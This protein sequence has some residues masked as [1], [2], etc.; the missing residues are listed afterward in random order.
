MENLNLRK[1]VAEALGCKARILD[2]G[3]I[4]ECKEVET[5]IRHVQEKSMILIKP[6]EL[7]H[8]AA[9]DALEEYCEKREYVWDLCHGCDGYSCMI[10]KPAPDNYLIL[11]NESN[12]SLAIAICEAIKAAAEGK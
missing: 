6:Y 1:A 11:A 10:W 9:L 7:D 4:C 12:N 2:I 3:L 5:I 8:H